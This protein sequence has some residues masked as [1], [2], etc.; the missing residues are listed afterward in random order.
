[1]CWWSYRDRR[2]GKKKKKKILKSKLASGPHESHKDPRSSLR[3]KMQPIQCLGVGRTS[4]GNLRTKLERSGMPMPPP[5]ENHPL[6]PSPWSTP[7]SSFLRRRFPISPANFR[8]K[9]LAIPSHLS[10]AHKSSFSEKIPPKLLISASAVGF[11]NTWT[12]KWKQT[13]A[14][15]PL[16]R[17]P[18]SGNV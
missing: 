16:A 18:K 14:K 3:R 9:I 2:G 1:M 10:Q 8:P 13:W 7:Q 15:K 17:F 12:A 6:P 4:A 5:W 11:L